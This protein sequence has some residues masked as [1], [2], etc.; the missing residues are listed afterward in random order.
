ML[1][2]YLDWNCIT[3]SKDLYPYIL[4]ICEE[5]SDRFIFPYSNA[6]IRDLMV[7]KKDCPNYYEIDKG[8]LQRICNRHLLYYE[9]GCLKPFFGYP[10]DFIDTFGGTYEAIQN[11]ELI[12][13]ETFETIKN[14]I[15]QNIPDDIYQKIQGAEPVDAIRI[16]DNFIASSQL[17]GKKDLWS[18]MDSV[19]E[20][21]AGLKTLESHF[22]SVCLALGLFG[23]RPE[24]KNKGLM[25]I[26]TDASHVFYAAHCDLFVTD[27]KKLKDKAIAMYSRYGFQTKVIRPKEFVN[28]VDEELKK[29]YSL[30]QIPDIIES[31]GVP[32]IEDDK[33]HYKLLYSPVFGLFNTCHK[34][35]KQWGYMGDSCVGLF[36]YSFSN[37]P[38]LFYTE[39]KHL[40][41]FIDSFLTPQEKEKFHKNYVELITSRDIEK[42]AKASYTFQC[43]DFGF[44]MIL[45]SDPD[46][47]VPC[48]MMMVNVGDKVTFKN[49]L[50]QIKDK[51]NPI[52]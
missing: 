48:P 11:M 21:L 39:M 32:R 7:C 41:N 24:N 13:K 46:T 52:C 44:Q 2:I 49:M 8:L 1:K 17:L 42:T 28:F 40:F 45:I 34:I 36:R 50:N 27:D 14:S 20:P 6:H 37:T 16:I 9:N 10:Q 33:L 31:Y 26:D 47:A 35:D 5:C 38:Y 3:H 18:L 29:E 12:T 43:D 4:S 15:K 51:T 22:K 23:F 25:N 19:P 30:F